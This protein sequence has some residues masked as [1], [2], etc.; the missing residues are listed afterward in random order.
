MPTV[1]DP[2]LQKTDDICEFLV[3]FE[4]KDV[5]PNSQL[6]LKNFIVVWELALLNCCC[7]VDRFGLTERA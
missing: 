3:I 1:M 7:R 2:K 6:P 5:T 4:A